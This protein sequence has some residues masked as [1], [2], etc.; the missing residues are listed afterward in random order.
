MCLQ[1]ICLVYMYKKDLALNSP[2]RLI[3]HKPQPK[4]TK[5]FNCVPIKTKVAKYQYLK[6]FE[7]VQTKDEC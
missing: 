6:L 4:Q 5:S 3:W 1:I 7:C 2:R